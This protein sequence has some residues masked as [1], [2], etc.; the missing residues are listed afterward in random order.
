MS[1]R[2]SNVSMLWKYTLDPTHVVDWA[3]LIIDTDGTCEEG[4]MRI[5]D[6]LDQVLRR[7]NVSLVKVFWKHRGVEEEIWERDDTMHAT[8]PFLFKDEGTL[9]SHLVIK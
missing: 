1:M 8:Y 2:Y 4:P 5:M 6:S 9:F 7:K 3:E